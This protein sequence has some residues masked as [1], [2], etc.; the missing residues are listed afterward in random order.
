MKVIGLGDVVYWARVHHF[1]GIYEV[2]ELKVRTVYE[3]C[4]VG[5]DKD[6]SRAFIISYDECDETV[7]DNREDAV[8]VVKNAEKKKKEFTVIEDG[9][10]E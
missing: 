8:R 4:F 6:T 1:T 2:Y 7:F 9:D 10:S 5:T 3:N